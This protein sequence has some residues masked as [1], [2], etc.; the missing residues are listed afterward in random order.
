MGED[1]TTGDAPPRRSLA[2]NKRI[3]VADDDEA[4]RIILQMFLEAKGYEVLLASDGVEAL[5]MI[6]TK[7]P[8]VVLL[9]IMMPQVDGIEVLRELRATGNKIGVIMITSITEAEVGKKAL[10]MG[11]FDHITKPFELQYLENV[12][13]WKLQM[14]KE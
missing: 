4:T 10:A 8:A 7:K 2:P 6:Q 14:L 12:L 3:L 5:E 11:A 9:D 13:W 1:D